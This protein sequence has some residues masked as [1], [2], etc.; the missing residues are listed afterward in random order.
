MVARLQN[1][2]AAILAAAL[3]AY[4]GRPRFLQWGT[5]SAASASASGV[6]ATGTTEARVEGVTSVATTTIT[7]D[8]YRVVGTIVAAGAVE[9][10]ELGV[11]DTAGTGTPPTGGVMAAYFDFSPINLTAGESIAFTADLKMAAVA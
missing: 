6:T 5:G 4:A 2:G 3:A 10:T 11:F 9:V 8:T 1:A 7:G